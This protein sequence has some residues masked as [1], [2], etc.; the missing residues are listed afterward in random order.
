MKLPD[1]KQLH[2]FTSV[3][4]YGGFRRA[5][6]HLGVSQP[7]LSKKVQELEDLLGRV[8]LQRGAKGVYPTEAGVALAREAEGLIGQARDLFS[9][10]AND[11]QIPRG[12]V[13]LAA[14]TSVGAILAPR[15]AE[16][17]ARDHPDIRL[18]LQEAAIPGVIDHVESG[19]AD[20]GIA[21]SPIL[22][23]ALV[24]EPIISEEIVVSGL[25][26]PSDDPFVSSDFLASAPLV[27]RP[28]PHGI[29]LTVDQL[30]QRMGVQ[31]SPAIEVDGTHT[32]ISLL[33]SGR[34]Y[35]IAPTTPLRRY[36][37]E[38][39]LQYRRIA[40]LV[41]RHLSLVSQREKPLSLAARA[42]ARCAVEILR[43]L[44]LDV[45]PVQPGIAAPR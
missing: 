7:V 41:Y 8:L 16:A 33:L 10:L 37:S 31:F 22:R 4:K 25:H 40:P 45:L 19:R 3:V 27:M 5:S 32:T 11:P 15:L 39:R 18:F 23:N 12:R 2:Y 44:Q 35:S 20:L 24:E 14:P 36:I 1:L 17:L 42:V 38:G 34:Y 21:S 28:P 26:F 13:A 43:N 30:G 29:R 9:N 6:F